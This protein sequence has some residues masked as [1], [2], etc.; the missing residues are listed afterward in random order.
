MPNGSKY[1]SLER[2]A[3]TAEWQKASL[4]SQFLFFAQVQPIRCATYVT[5]FPTILIAMIYSMYRI[6][7]KAKRKNA[8]DPFLDEL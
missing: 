2:N 1:L 5:A 7:K 6:C 3:K 8:K 4:I